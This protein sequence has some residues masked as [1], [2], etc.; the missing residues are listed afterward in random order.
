MNGWIVHD[1]R[2]VSSVNVATSRQAKRIGLKAHPD[3]SIP[4]IIESCRWVHTF[5]MRFPIDVAFLD[6]ENSV[7][8]LR[9]MK[10]NRLG[11]PVR[12]AVRVVETEPGAFHHW[13]LKIGDVID[14]HLSHLDGAP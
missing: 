2:V 4:L 12:R 6:A 8:A 9:E 14:I 7:V 5:G 1:T 10:P 13:G 11:M 3:A